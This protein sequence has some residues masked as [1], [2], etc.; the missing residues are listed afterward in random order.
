MITAIYSI[1]LSTSRYPET[2]LGRADQASMV[3]PLQSS[4]FMYETYGLLH[5]PSS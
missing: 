5:I 2:V 3:A 1:P 4:V